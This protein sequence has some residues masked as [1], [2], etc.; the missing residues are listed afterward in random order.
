MRLPDGRRLTVARYG[1]PGRPPIVYMHGFLGSR[2]EP[3][4]ALPADAHVLAVDR[5]GYGG[6]DPQPA[7]SLRAFGADVAAALDRLGA[8]E[9]TLVGISAGAPY[10]L[11]AGI[12]LGA[13]VR[14]CV[15]AAGV[16]GPDAVETAGGAVRLFRRR[17]QALRR[18]LRM[19]APAL[20]DERVA[21]TF[22]ALATRLA[23][24]RFASAAERRRVVR[25]LSSS[26]AEAVRT[27]PA[28]A[29]ADIDLI[30]RPWDVDPGELRVPCLVLHGTDDPVVPAAHA[31]WYGTHL[32]QGRVELVAARGHIAFLVGQARRIVAALG[33]PATFERVQT[34]QYNP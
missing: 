3:C 15:L 1:P 29:L 28:G 20:R 17:P 2:L 4:A 5:P 7:P 8:G 24:E 18:L 14:A 19:A 25:A 32:P 23:H 26:V 33:H 21:R 9:V 6:T 22:L 10:A 27:G 30:G 16:A 11:A 34:H 13:R 31:E 12:V